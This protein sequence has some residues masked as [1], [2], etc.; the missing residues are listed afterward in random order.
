MLTPT[1]RRTFAPRGRTPIHYSWD[2]RDRISAISAITISP[3]RRR[4]G[5][6]FHLL[7]DN[8]NVHA[9]DVVCFLGMLWRQLRRPLT[10]IW[11]GSRVHDRAKAV[12]GYLRTH[13]RIVTEKLPAYA[14]D[15]NPDEGV[16]GHTKYARL[17]NFA[18][19]DTNHLRKQ[20]TEQLD[21]LRHCSDLLA[22][23][24]KHTKLPIR[25]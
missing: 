13:R 1:V 15:L 19:I 2:R 23:F 12:Q 24:V 5:L 16:W 20:L 11:D 14:P 22:A 7:P 10:V 8:E 3:N 6:Y 9:N 21:E 4:L 17:C 25:L 18:P